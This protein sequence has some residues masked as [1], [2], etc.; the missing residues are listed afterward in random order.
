MQ[1]GVGTPRTV[2]DVYTLK[3]MSNDTLRV[4]RTRSDIACVL[5]NPLQSLHP[6]ATAPSDA[7]L[8]SSDR[9][10]CFDRD[11]YT[12]WLQELRRVCTE[13]SIVLIVDEVFVGFRI[14]YGGA[15]EYFGVER[16]YRHLRQDARRRPA[17]RSGLRQTPVHETLPRRSPDRRLLRPRN[18][19]LPSVRDGGM[20]EFLKRLDDPSIRDSYR[21][22]EATGIR[23]RRH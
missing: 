10:A 7:S 16:G 15:Q 4:L 18:L 5:V 17:D 13:R 12:R 22:G 14:A 6:N 3:D 2:H 20:N 1:P 11:G 9:T 21:T 19:Q 23:A 8:V